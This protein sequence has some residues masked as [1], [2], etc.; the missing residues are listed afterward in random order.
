M[1]LV[2]YVRENA[3]LITILSLLVSFGIVIALNPIVIPILRK[4]KFGQTIRE[5]GP[6]SHQKKS[7]T[8]TM[9]GVIFLCAITVVSL[10]LIIVFKC[11][12]IIPVLLLTLGFGAIGFVDDMIIVI[13]KRNE[14]LTEIQK[15]LAQIVVTAIFCVYLVMKVGTTISIPFAYGV[16]WTMP[17]WLFVIFIFIVVVGTV[18]GANFTD[19]LDGLATSVT[20]VIA[21]FFMI[22]T[23]KL[24]LTGHG[25]MAMSGA[26]VGSLLGFLTVNVYPAS[27]F[28]GDTGS[29]ALGGFVAGMACVMKMPIIIVLIAFI[30]LIEVISVMI[31]VAYFK[32]T[33]KKFGEGR[34]VFRMAPLHHHFQ[35][36]GQSETQVV[37][38]FTIITLVLC[39]VAFLGI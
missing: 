35:E 8:P 17:T 13:A 24:G 30:Y 33:K 3:L 9:G 10:F 5:E 27:V 38:R 37:T 32:Y 19:G 39:L 12:D 28:M 21:A 25:Y 1:G 2:E 4:L 29:L 14:G 6:K 36:G 7:G 34:R 16:K 31:Q 18:N 20:I 11:Y 26:V 23:R 15:F 22:A